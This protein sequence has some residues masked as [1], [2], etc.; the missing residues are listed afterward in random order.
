MAFRITYNNKVIGTALNVASSEITWNTPDIIY[1]SDG[2]TIFAQKSASTGNYLNGF[3]V[4]FSVYWNYQNKRFEMRN[5]TDSIDYGVI[6][7]SATNWRVI[8]PDGSITRYPATLNESDGTPILEFSSAGW[9]RLVAGHPLRQV[10]NNQLFS[11]VADNYEGSTD[12][13]LTY[14]VED[15][16]GH[17]V[18]W[19]GLYNADTDI[20][21]LDDFVV[22]QPN[23]TLLGYANYH[24]SQFTSVI[25]DV[26]YGI[27][28]PSVIALR[29]VAGS[30]DPVEV[31][32]AN[33]VHG[34]NCWVVCGYDEYSTYAQLQPS[35]YSNSVSSPWCGFI[36]K[37][38][39]QAVY[40]FCVPDGTYM[41]DA[42]YDAF[43]NLPEGFDFEFCPQCIQF[44]GET[45]TLRFIDNTL[46]PELGSHLIVPDVS[47]NATRLSLP[48]GNTYE[49]NIN[50]Q[51][52]LVM[53]GGQVLLFPINSTSWLQR[54]IGVSVSVNPIMDY[55]D[56]AHVGWI[57]FPFVQI[58]SAALSYTTRS[59]FCFDFTLLAIGK[60]GTESVRNR[61]MSYPNS[62]IA[63][64]FP[65]GIVSGSVGYG[66]GLFITNVLSGA[67][68]YSGASYNSVFTHLQVHYMFYS[69][70]GV[71]ETATSTGL[72]GLHPFY[73]FSEAACTLTANFT[74]AQ[75][76][77]LPLVANVVYNSSVPTKLVTI[78]G[79]NRVK[80]RW[81]LY[82]Y[83]EVSDTANVTHSVQRYLTN[84][85]VN[86]DM[87]AMNG[88]APGLYD[89]LSSLADAYNHLISGYYPH[90]VNRWRGPQGI[91]FGGVPSTSNFSAGGKILSTII[92]ANDELD[93][94]PNYPYKFI[95]RGNG[96]QIDVFSGFLYDEATQPI[97][98][99]SVSVKYP[100]NIKSIVPHS[101]YYEGIE[102]ARLNEEL[103]KDTYKRYDVI[104]ENWKFGVNGQYDFSI[105]DYLVMRPGAY[106]GNLAGTSTPDGRPFNDFYELTSEDVYSNLFAWCIF[107][108]YENISS[109]VVR[110]NIVRRSNN[111][112]LIIYSNNDGQIDVIG[113]FL[114]GSIT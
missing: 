38:S 66:D 89:S 54:D 58:N 94:Y 60:N 48:L 109:G 61:E 50:Y 87:P 57:S 106:S 79:Y 5:I 20:G 77:N 44:A 45:H 104:K 17:P 72:G 39:K 8:H 43:H 80:H 14:R 81:V 46:Y 63:D 19:V 73:D 82:P 110:S 6:D 67:A 41:M 99:R 49:N 23:G 32:N 53:I 91:T 84:V 98:N 86:V 95:V 113:N 42:V 34:G 1:E 93:E 96:H 105:T 36:S 33:Y 15:P 29:C 78:I 24:T 18:G 114:Y 47:R 108:Y 59:G 102:I 11:V 92:Y 62:K 76:A 13:F 111:N 7:D 30:S 68:G 37:S 12:N 97:V 74:S 112:A 31:E 51:Y 101:L 16:D 65:N 25:N 52:T 103:S 70:F 40:D 9:Y 21:R 35:V 3:N 4:E 71:P 28:E 27:F 64:G 88:W 69:H 83:L 55:T 85:L 107:P 100:D 56:K 22:Y 75:L 90:S 2:R 10:Y 26:V